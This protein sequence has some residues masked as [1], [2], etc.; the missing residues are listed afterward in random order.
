MKRINV[1]QSA[2][3]G[4]RISLQEEEE[5]PGIRKLEFRSKKLSETIRYV[6]CINYIER[7]VIMLM[8]VHLSGMQY[9]RLCD[10]K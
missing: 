6:R 5:G 4:K 8:C 1:S 3:R 9:A 2:H 10:Q 7:R